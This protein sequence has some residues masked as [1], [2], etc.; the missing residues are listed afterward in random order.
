M[1]NYNFKCK[2][3]KC[4]K[5]DSYPDLKSAYMDGWWF[6]KSQTCYDCGKVVTTAIQNNEPN[7]VDVLTIQG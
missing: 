4:N 5:E 6:G 1:S 7:I 2:C 3:S